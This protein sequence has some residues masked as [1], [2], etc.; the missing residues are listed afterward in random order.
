MPKRPSE[1][2]SDEQA[3]SRAR[4]AMYQALTTPYKPQRAMVGKT[5]PST[6]KGKTKKTPK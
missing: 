5:K 3:E 6:R 4:A 2:Y 1:E